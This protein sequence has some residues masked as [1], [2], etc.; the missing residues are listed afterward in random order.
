MRDQCAVIFRQARKDLEV[1]GLL[2]ENK[3]DNKTTSNDECLASNI[4]KE[5]ENL[6]V[7]LR[8]KSF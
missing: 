2:D 4:D 5:L 1:S 3:D 6:S 8:T 7:S